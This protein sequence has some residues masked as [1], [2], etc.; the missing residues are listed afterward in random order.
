MLY[1]KK[2]IFFFFGG[3]V[4]SKAWYHV[5]QMYLFGQSARKSVKVNSKSFSVLMH[6]WTNWHKMCHYQTSYV[7]LPGYI[8]VNDQ[9]NI[10]SLVERGLNRA[11]GIFHI[12]KQVFHRPRYG[13]YSLKFSCF[14]WSFCPYRTFSK[15]FL[16]DDLETKVLLLSHS[17]ITIIELH[18]ETNLV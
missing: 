12:P 15:H 5:N 1:Q 13:N 3:G 8:W 11:K 2:K 14:R 6:R 17:L 10:C 16:C 4:E 18:S 9:G 7:Y